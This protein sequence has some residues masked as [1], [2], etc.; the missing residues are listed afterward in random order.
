MQEQDVLVIDYHKENAASLLLPRPSVLSSGGLAR[1]DWQNIHLEISQQPKFATADHQHP[2]HVLAYVLDYAQTE[3]GLDSGSRWLDGK[4]D[5]ERRNIGDI[6]VI[7]AG[8]IHRC[9]WD[10][11]V[12]F[13]ILAIEPTFLKQ[14]GQDWVNSDCIELV[15]RFANQSDPLLQGIFSTLKEEIESS[16]MGGHLLLDSLKTALAIHLLR[17]YCTTR[18]RL[19]D[20][21]DG[22]SQSS[23]QQVIAYINAHLDRDLKLVEL[24]TIAQLSPYHFLRLFKQSMGT[25]PH[26]YIL[27]CRIEKTK[28]LLRHSTLS[29]AEIAARVGFSDQSHLTRYFKRVVGVTPK[30]FLQT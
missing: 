17:K 22:L 12:Q 2:M 7:P 11:S 15:P 28:Q 10:T 9:S 6:A 23:L 30:Q 14:I 26:Q 29:L 27:Q 4:R 24:A 19:S 21:G 3:P 13:G 25:T 8:M 16:G 20:Y 18:P 5:R 1:A